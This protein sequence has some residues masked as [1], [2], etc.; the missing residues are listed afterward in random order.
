MTKRKNYIDLKNPCKMQWEDLNGDSCVRRCDLCNMNV[1]DFTN[2]TSDEILEY[3]MNHKGRVCAKINTHQT[4]KIYSSKGFNFKLLRAFT[5][6][7]FGLSTFSVTDLKADNTSKPLSVHQQLNTTL[8]P[9]FHKEKLVRDS[10][11]VVRGRVFDLDSGEALPG[12]NVH[13]KGSTHGTT[14]DVDGYFNLP[15]ANEKKTNTLVFSFIGYESK[16]VEISNFNEPVEVKMVVNVMQL[17]EISIPWYK[18][19]WW[20]LSSPFRKS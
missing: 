6:I 4:D 15:I 3:V 7:A 13:L 12:I 5:F 14:T 20:S 2:K 19:L 11:T 10:V 16:E 1:V 17:G 8:T 18:R 9:I